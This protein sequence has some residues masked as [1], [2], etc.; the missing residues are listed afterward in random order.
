MTSFVIRREG[1]DLG[2]VIVVGA[3]TMAT[4]GDERSTDRGGGQ[5]LHVGAEWIAKEAVDGRRV[6]KR[7]HQEGIGRPGAR[8]HLRGASLEDAAVAGKKREYLLD[9]VIE[10]F[11]RASAPQTKRELD[12]GGLVHL[13]TL[14]RRLNQRRT[15]A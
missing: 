9:I 2:I 8:V 15:V 14:L 5:V 12:A 7:H 13:S 6:G 1:N 10:R 4:V 3:L 11:G